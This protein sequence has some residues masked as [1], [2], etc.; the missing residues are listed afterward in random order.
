MF[1]VNQKPPNHCTGLVMT[2][3]LGVGDDGKADAGDD[4]GKGGK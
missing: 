4:D 3:G 2:I 1:P